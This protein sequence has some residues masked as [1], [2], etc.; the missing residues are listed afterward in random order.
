MIL[1]CGFEWSI[2][3]GAKPSGARLGA[4]YVLVMST[5]PE[6]ARTLDRFGELCDRAAQ[7]GLHVCLEFAI[8]TG[9]RTLA[10]AARL[11]R[12]SGRP[13]ASILVDALHF[14]R[15]GGVPADIAPFV[16]FLCTDG[17]SY[18]TGQTIRIDGGF[19]G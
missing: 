7:Y 10:H 3:C 11:I 14:S 5:E 13:N 9:V 1:A 16:S 4:K 18:V 2:L 17:A 15:S 6:E 8:Y 12:Q 19:T